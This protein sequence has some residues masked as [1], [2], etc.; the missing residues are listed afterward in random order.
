MLF[1]TSSLDIRMAT[2][3]DPLDDASWSTCEKWPR[4]VCGSDALSLLGDASMEVPVACTCIDR[5]DGIGSGET[6]LHLYPPVRVLAR[7]L[8]LPPYS[9]DP[10]NHCC[11]TDF[12]HCPTHNVPRAV[13]PPLRRYDNFT[14]RRVG[15]AVDLFRQLFEGL[16]FL[17]RNY[18][19]HRDCTARHIAMHAECPWP[20]YY[21]TL[22][23]A[24][25]VYEPY[26][27]PLVFPRVCGDPTV[28]EF[29]A[30]PLSPHNPFQTDVYCLGNLVRR[31]FLEVFSNLDFM[32]DLVSEMV[33]A[34]PS[35]RP[36]MDEVIDEFE[37]AVAGLS[38]KMLR[39]PLRRRRSRLVDFILRA[40]F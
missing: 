37:A 1:R 26:E 36:P 5:R 10:W 8:S 2:P 13:T 21:F 3:D 31:D 24:S 16:E 9:D 35:R 7:C 38:V 4:D 17:H 40:R 19:T 39:R 29:Q 11:P 33:Q 18:I 34:D 28:P 12:I 14:F 23:P 30:G 6:L 25:R 32:S 20:Q 15:E 27:E 22:S